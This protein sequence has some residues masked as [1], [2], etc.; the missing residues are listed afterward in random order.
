M[1]NALQEA[2][3][4]LDEITVPKETF[5]GLYYTGKLNERK[6][7][8]REIAWV[9]NMEDMGLAPVVSSGQNSPVYGQGTYKEWRSA[10]IDIRFAKR[11]TTDELNNLVSPDKR[12]RI[13][14]K[15]HIAREMSDMMRRAAHTQEY[16]AHCAISRGAVNYVCNDPSAKV[17]LSLS[18]PIKDKTAGTLW[19]DAANSTPV[20]DIN[21]WIREH[22]IAGNKFPDVMR[23]STLVWNLLKA[24]T[25][26]KA[27]YTN[28]LR[29]SNPKIGDIPGGLVTPEMTAKA[30]GWP[31]IQIYNERTAVKF[32]AKNNET[33]GS[34]VVI[35]LVDE[36]GFNGTFGINVGDKILVDYA[37]GSWTE[38]ASV[39]AIVHGTSVTA[40]IANNITAGD[41]IVCK[42]TFHP[43][44]RVSLISDEMDNEFIL[45]PYGI[46]AVGGEIRLSNWYGLKAH[47]FDGGTEPNINVYRRVWNSLG[48]KLSN[49]NKILSAKVR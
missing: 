34:N 2:R 10:A 31:T 44:D 5:S 9:R 24:T 22:E 11:F 30:F 43:E 42:P 6:S 35:E 28:F 16:L 7:P 17:N 49:P 47:V 15:T 13:E 1:A 26:F 23:M 32:T 39:S 3:Q 46:E 19:S 36:R 8:T 33:A 25:Q 20:D 29:L 41:V 18:F 4:L 14:A 12:Y 48:V 45:A 40:T 38:E 27:Q 21:S 37:D